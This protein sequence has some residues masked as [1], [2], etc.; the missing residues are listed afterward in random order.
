MQ[1]VSKKPHRGFISD[2]CALY[3]QKVKIS[4]K[5]MYLEIR[6]VEGAL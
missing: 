6:R 4:I 3:K 5:T 2:D 1:N